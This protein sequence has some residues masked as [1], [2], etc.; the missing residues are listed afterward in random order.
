MISCSTSNMG[1]TRAL[2]DM[3]TA[4]PHNLF[5][6]CKSQQILTEFAKYKSYR[7]ILTLPAAVLVEM[8]PAEIISNEHHYDSPRVKEKYVST[9]KL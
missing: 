1:K 8:I 4:V 5:F 3:S 9:C 6:S 7:I 2:K